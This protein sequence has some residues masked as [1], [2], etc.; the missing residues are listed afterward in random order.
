MTNCDGNCPSPGNCEPCND[1]LYREL[2]ADDA[3]QESYAEWLRTS[4]PLPK[5]TDAHQD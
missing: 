3:M 4:G 1:K 5:E 2:I